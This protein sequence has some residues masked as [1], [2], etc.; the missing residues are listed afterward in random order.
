[1]SGYLQSLSSAPGSCADIRQELKALL[2]LKVSGTTYNALWKNLE[3][4]LGHDGAVSFVDD[5]VDFRQKRKT[6]EK[7]MGKTSK[8]LAMAMLTDDRIRLEKAARK[9]IKKQLKDSPAPPA[10]KVRK[11][12]PDHSHIRLSER[13]YGTSSD[14]VAI[15]API[16][17]TKNIKTA[18]L[19]GRSS[20]LEKHLEN[21]LQKHWLH[22]D[23]G[24]GRRLSLI[25]N[26]VRLSQTHEK[27]DLLAQAGS[28][29]VPIELKIKE[30]GGS[31]LTQV[32][33]YRKDAIRQGYSPENVLGI[34]VA[35]KFSS[36]VLNIVEDMP[37]IILR[38]F[39]IPL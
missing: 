25:D 39:E 13:T 26:Q 24:V 33:S 7:V 11:K 34:L 15:Y 5:F 21:Y 31:D 19:R 2:G 9:L 1:M 8:T 37:G 35:P 28:L 4:H 36:K 30:A 23:F 16:L 20:W 14:S 22:L 32:Q 6:L 12:I 17:E 18:P 3:L 10:R 38:W 29:I 27:V